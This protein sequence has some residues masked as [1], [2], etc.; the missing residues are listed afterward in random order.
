[1]K[2]KANRV[3]A[4][5]RSP[6]AAVRAVLL[7][8]PDAGLVRERAQALTLTVAGD[9]SDPFRVAELTGAA[10]R[11]DPPTLNDEAAALSL[12]GGRR[13]V[14]VRDAGDEVASVFEDFLTMASGDTL[15]IVEAGE[16]SPRSKLRRLIEAAD[17]ATA[18]PCYMD[19]GEALGGLIRATLGND[20]I[21]VEPD[22]LAFLMANL[23]SDRMITRHELEKLALYAGEG[24]RIVLEDA[25]ACVGDSATLS[26]QDIALA[27]ANGDQAGLE[28]SLT[29]AYA[30]N[31]AP[32]AILRSVARHFQ[33]L[34][35]TA[36]HVAAGQSPERAVAA[37]RPPV[38]FKV[39][40]Q[41]VAQLKRWPPIR[42]GATLELLTQ[43]E[44]SC[45]TTGIP[46]EVICARALMSVASGAGRR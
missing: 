12:T 1:M 5:L 21:T 7:Y 25:I 43:A 36:G 42:L 14:R 29:R 20:R 23:G 18:L 26:L 24:G 46:A 45:K 3:D 13:V 6:D 32:V 27:V 17:N 15:V 8:G 37:L 40:G 30:E 22:A 41:F 11:Q 35:L 10:I 44:I 9:L 2:I 28:R 16:L 33:R 4:F 31:L 34:H 38:F 39:K 19:E